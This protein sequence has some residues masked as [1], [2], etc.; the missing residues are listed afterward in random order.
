MV[1]GLGALAATGLDAPS[2]WAAMKQGESAIKPIANI[3]VTRLSVRIAAEIV[4]FQ[5]GMHFDDKRLLML[6]RTAQFALVAAREATRDVDLS[7]VQPTRGGVILGAAL[8]QNSFETAYRDFYEK[9]QNRF[10][11]LTLPRCM[12]SAAASL[13]SMEFGLRG[14]CFSTASACASASHAI[15]LAFQMIRAGMLDIVLTGGADA[16]IT[17]GYLK[18]WEAMRVLSPEACRPFSRDRTGLVIGEGA[19]ILLLEERERAVARGADILAEVAGFGMSA[20]AGDITAPNEV[21]AVQ[22]MNEALADAGVPA[23]DIGYINAHGTGTRLND[24]TE[25]AAIR[26]VFGTDPPPA[27]SSKSMI[28]H[29]LCAGGALEFA[30]TVLA[31][32]DGMLPPTAGFR[33]AD[34]ECDI[35]CVANS[36]RPAAIDAALSNSFAFGGLNAVL[37]ARRA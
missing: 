22:A 21:G 25:T 23:A 37:V 17:P 28:G 16:S 24:R 7:D 8:G 32:R 1:T 12:P 35:D 15:G 14:A 34:P 20:D 6:D 13:V 5:P 18:A 31:L 19:A 9:K 10:P 11:P 4:D 27:S 29:C 3:D 30:A 33:E 36:A 26:R 2:V